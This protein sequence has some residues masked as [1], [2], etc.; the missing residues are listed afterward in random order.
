MCPEEYGARVR[1]Q[2]HQ[3]QEA[4]PTRLPEVGEGGQDLQE[5]QPPQ[6]WYVLSLFLPVL[7]AWITFSMNN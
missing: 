5:A 6:H 2:D 4:F 7:P 3:H 1:S